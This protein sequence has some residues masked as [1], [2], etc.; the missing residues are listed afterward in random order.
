MFVQKLSRLTWF[1]LGGGVGGGRGLLTWFSDEG[2]A[3]MTFTF[4]RTTREIFQ[5]GTFQFNIIARNEKAI[6]RENFSSWRFDS[7]RIFKIILFFSPT[8]VT[9][10]YVQSS[11]R[12]TCF[13]PRP[14]G[15]FPW[16]WVGR[17]TQSQGKAPWG[18]GWHA[19]ILTFNFVVFDIFAYTSYFLYFCYT[20]YL[21]CQWHGSLFCYVCNCLYFW[22]AAV[23]NCFA[24]SVLWH[25]AECLSSFLLDWSMLW[26]SFSRH[27]ESSCS[28]IGS[29]KF[30]LYFLKRHWL[31]STL[32][33]CESTIFFMFFFSII[34]PSPSLFPDTATTLDYIV[35]RVMIRSPG[36]GA[37][38]DGWGEDNAYMLSMVIKLFV[39]SF[40]LDQLIT[41]W[42]ISMQISTWFELMK[43]NGPTYTHNMSAFAPWISHN[44]N[45]SS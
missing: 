1:F 18:R 9:I 32:Y 6:F 15:A 19:L 20:L 38:G 44:V 30:P 22:S 16:L 17:G 40:N 34:F 12:R 28:F 13:Q 5:F 3:I 31:Y 45:L 7:G 21:L 8:T 27:L 43:P 10:L 37:V 35:L 26:N 14:L 39:F 2:L 25:R 41:S 23:T 33:K 11:S 29:V 36:R 42:Y 24:H 4:F